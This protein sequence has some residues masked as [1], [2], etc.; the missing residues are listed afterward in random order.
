MTGD[1]IKIRSRGEIT[2]PEKLRRELGLKPQDYINIY[3]DEE[4]VISIKKVTL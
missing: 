4:G 3:I 1:I 2:I